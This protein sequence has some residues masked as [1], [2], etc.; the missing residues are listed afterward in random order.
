MPRNVPY[1]L[2]IHGNHSK[3]LNESRGEKCTHPEEEVSPSPEVPITPH[4]P[5]QARNEETGRSSFMQVALICLI[6]GAVL[7][8]LAWRVPG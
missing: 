6:L 2:Y 4:S 8:G 1:S 3:T 7:F 5:K